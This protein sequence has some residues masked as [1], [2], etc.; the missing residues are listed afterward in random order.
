MK[1]LIVTTNN[2]PHNGTCSNII[3][4]LIKVGGLGKKHSID[5]LASKAN[6]KDL[7]QEKID[8]VS[9]TRVF[10]YTLLN[11]KAFAEIRKTSILKW[12]EGT[13]KR[14][15]FH[16]QNIFIKSDFIDHTTCNAFYKKLKEIHA[17]QYDCII[18]ISGRYDATAGVLHFCKSHDAKMVLYQVDPCASNRIYDSKSK[19][20]RMRFERELINCSSAVL[21]TPIIFK[22]CHYDENNKNGNIV[23]VEFPLIIPMSRNHVY[24]TPKRCVFLGSFYAGIRDPSFTLDVFTKLVKKNKAELWFVGPNESIL[25]EEHNNIGIKCFGRRTIE[26]CNEI[27]DD[28][29]CLINIGNRINNQVPSKI[30]DYISTGKPIINIS[31]LTDDPCIPYLSKYPLALTIYEGDQ[32]AASKVE[33]FLESINNVLTDSEIEKIYQECTPN[34]VVDVMCHT[35]EMRI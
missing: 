35:I 3:K 1:L 22:E 28:A 18:S 29:D 2:Y 16:Y 30:F 7:D 21:T 27:M 5:I 24:K 9:V 31:A 17:E 4:K 19:I 12:I 11:K 15:I 14:T 13:I 10:S 25:N 26:E 32:T 34:Y 8:G 20:N 23:P 6:F 33:A